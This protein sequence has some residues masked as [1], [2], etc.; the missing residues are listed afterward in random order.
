MPVV[1]VSQVRIVAGLLGLYGTLY[2]AVDSA[3]PEGY[4]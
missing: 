2:N 1:H 4:R 3:K